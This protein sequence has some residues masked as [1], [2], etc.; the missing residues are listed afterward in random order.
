LIDAEADTD[1][2]PLTDDAIIDLNTLPTSLLNIRVDVS[3]VVGS[4]KFDVNEGE[5]TRTEKQA[6][7]SLIGDTDGDYDTWRPDSTSYT[8]TVTLYQ[9][10]DGQEPLGEPLTLSFTITE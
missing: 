7:Y 8:L 1:I 5:I 4:V 10:A 3:D 6:P 9:D 2:M